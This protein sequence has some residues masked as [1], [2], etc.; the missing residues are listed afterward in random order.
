ML[1]DK[2]INALFRKL[3]VVDD[4]GLIYGLQEACRAVIEANNA[5]ILADLKPAE[6]ALIEG[7]GNDEYWR[8]SET[9]EP[10]TAAYSPNTVSALI[11]RNEALEACLKEER[12]LAPTRKV[13]DI[14]EA[15]AYSPNEE[16]QEQN[17]CDALRDIRESVD[18][19]EVALKKVLLAVQAYL[20]PD[21][22][23][24]DDFI[25]RVIACVDPWPT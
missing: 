5:K 2:E 12:I 4:D 25:S 13:L 14:W 24:K 15:R 6:F 10:H 9:Y 7:H 1:T 20:P 22:I 23:T 16:E 18:C 21:G 11:Q 3:V 17:L 8:L 19:T